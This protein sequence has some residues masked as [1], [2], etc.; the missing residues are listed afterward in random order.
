MIYRSQFLR[1]INSEIALFIVLLN[2]IAEISVQK[3][4]C[5]LKGKICL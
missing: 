2:L 4:K 3:L 1:E 5:C